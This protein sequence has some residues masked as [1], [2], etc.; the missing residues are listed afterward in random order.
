MRPIIIL[1]LLMMFISSLSS[2]SDSEESA[3]NKSGEEI[4]ARFKSLITGTV[5]ENWLIPE[6]GNDNTLYAISENQESARK[7]ATHIIGDDN[8]N[9]EKKTYTLPDGYGSVTVQT[10]ETEGLF[11]KM[12]F[13]VK[14]MRPLTLNIASD[15][16]ILNASNFLQ[17]PDFIKGRQ[18]ICLDCG[19]IYSWFQ[20]DKICPACGSSNTRDR[21]GDR[22]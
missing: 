2:C 11:L 20:S 3:A 15:D 16:Y 7:L 13:N 14:G 22:Y 18:G 10:T 21:W 5:S 6:E 17:Y 1:A 8:W 9:I 19:A 4:A 12:A